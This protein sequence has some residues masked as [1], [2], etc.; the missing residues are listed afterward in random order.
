MSYLFTNNKSNELPSNNLP[1]GSYSNFSD[2]SFWTVKYHRSG[3]IL[4]ID[5][6]E[7]RINNLN[8]ISTSVDYRHVGIY[9]K[10]LIFPD[11]NM[12]IEFTVKI[13]DVVNGSGFG[14]GPNGIG[15]YIAEQFNSFMQYYSTGG[16]APNLERPYI[17][18]REFNNTYSSGT[19][20]LYTFPSGTLWS[21]F[22]NGIILKCYFDPSDFRVKLSAS[23]DNGAS[24]FSCGST[25]SGIYW[26]NFTRLTPANGVSIFLGM[27]NDI[28]AQNSDGKITEFIITKGIMR[29]M[30]Y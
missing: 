13:Q 22:P 10:P 7:I 5:N 29:R 26:R 1:L 17:H 6:N 19:A 15:F 24:Y 9:F 11:N 14:T 2:E 4:T 3:P 23:T 12:E 16:F 28:I 25:G 30:I 8:L 20:R 27:Y 21:D 18:A